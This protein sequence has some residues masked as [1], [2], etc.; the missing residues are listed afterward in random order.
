MYISNTTYIFTLKIAV[1]KLHEIHLKI[2]ALFENCLC[3][4]YFPETKMIEPHPCIE[5]PIEEQGSSS[6]FFS[7]ESLKLDSS[8]ATLKLWYC[9]WAFS[10]VERRSEILKIM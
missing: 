4:N 5:S 8:L 6:K 10:P 2:L 3:L 7:K 9:T 1:K